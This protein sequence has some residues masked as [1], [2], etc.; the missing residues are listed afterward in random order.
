MKIAAVRDDIALQ[1][2]ALFPSRRFEPQCLGAL[3]PWWVTG[4]MEKQWGVFGSTWTALMHNPLPGK[5]P[6]K[7]FHLS[8]CRAA[9]GEFRNYSLVERDHI[10]KLF[11]KIILDTTA[12]A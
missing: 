8:P 9:Q 2:V 11:R 3:V 7:Q 1:T 6:L 10:T 4:L 5:P 12:I